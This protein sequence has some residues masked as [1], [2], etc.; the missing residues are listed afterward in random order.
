MLAATQP[1]APQQSVTQIGASAAL[2]Q[3]VASPVSGRLQRL[4]GVTQLK[5]VP[6]IVG[7]TNTP[8]A[9]LTLE[10]Q[11]TR[12]IDFIYIQDVTQSNSEVIRIEWNI[13]PTWT[14]VAERDI[15]GEF[16]VDLFYKK[17]F[18]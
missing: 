1:A 6:A 9:R 13:N 2:G 14:A 12:Q 8:Q 16:G 4:F 11:I 5:I 7:A 18:K 10:Q 15:Y 3:A 17:R